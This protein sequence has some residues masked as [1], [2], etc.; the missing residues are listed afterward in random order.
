MSARC[1][2]KTS[3]LQQIAHENL[4]MIL[5]NDDPNYSPEIF[6][7]CNL[8]LDNDCAYLVEFYSRNAL[9]V[10]KDYELINFVLYSNYTHLED[11]SEEEDLSESEISDE[12]NNN[13]IEED[14]YTLNNML[15][16]EDEIKQ[17]IFDI[18]SKLQETLPVPE[19]LELEDE[20]KE[21]LQEL[22]EIEKNSWE[23]ESRKFIIFD[24]TCLLPVRYPLYDQRKRNATTDQYGNHLNAVWSC[25]KC[26]VQSRMHFSQNLDSELS[27]YLLIDICPCRQICMR[28]ENGKFHNKDNLPTFIEKTISY[29]TTITIQWHKHGILMKQETLRL[30]RA[31][32]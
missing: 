13:Q 27:G 20:L 25:K 23:W 12:E 14:E 11:H 31:Q 29:N 18:R 21:S 3:K 17:D 4:N 22:E 32:K 6:Q 9:C 19:R 26:V 2:R 8:H 28:I 1:T 15:H 7:I 10:T 16:L 24:K 30:P 5:N